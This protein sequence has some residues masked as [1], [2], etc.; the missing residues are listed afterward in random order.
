MILLDGFNVAREKRLELKNEIDL[1]KEKYNKTPK[2]A[3]IVVGNEK[4]SATY[5]RNKM[6]ACKNTN[7]EGLL[8]EL[9]VEITE[10]ELQEKIDELN[11]DNS[12][13]GI[14]VQLPLPKH[15]NEYDVLNL[16]K[17]EK[18]VDG[19]TLINQGLLFKGKK[20]LRAATPQGMIDLL[21]YYKIDVSGMNA[22]VVGRSQIVGLPIAKMLID[23]NATV[24]VTHSRTKDLASHTKNADLLVVAIGRAKM[25]TKEMVKEGAIVLDVGINVIDSK[26]YGDVDFENVRDK[27]SYIT[28]VPRG[29]GPMTIYALLKNTYQ[30]FLNQNNINN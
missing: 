1:L 4:A 21:D 23:K 22:V 6:I 25:I 24:T 15:I 13:N 28:P 2:L 5:V 29:V 10:K 8:I 26:L 17:P 16:I 12:V 7:I 3:I 27:V 19:F 11:N 30:A 20:A 14:I 18:D 9:P